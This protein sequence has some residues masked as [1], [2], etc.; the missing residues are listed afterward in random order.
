MV[1]NTPDQATFIPAFGLLLA[2]EFNLVR[3][4]LHALLYYGI[5]SSHI[6]RSLR[7]IM[8]N[9]YMNYIKKRL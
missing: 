7:Y 1:V 4:V 3:N 2:W 6:D 8:K 5:I 9:Q